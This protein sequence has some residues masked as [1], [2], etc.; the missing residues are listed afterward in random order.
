VDTIHCLE[1]VFRN[2]HPSY[3]VVVC[4]NGSD[5]GSLEYI[6]EWAEG[7]RNAVTAVH[8]FLASL[9]TPPVAKPIQYVMYSRRSAEQGGDQHA[10]TAR[11]I[12]IRNEQNEGFAAGNNVA[13]RF[14]LARQDLAYAWI[15][16]N[17]TLVAPAALRALVRCVRRR[18]RVGICGSTLVYYDSP[19]VVQTRGGITYNRWFATIRAI[20]Q[21]TLIHEPCDVRR[22]ERMMSYPAG[23]S[24]LVSRDFLQ[25]VGL[26]SE[27]Y[28]LYCE[29]L[30]WATRARGRF[31]IAYSP[32]S[33]VYH[34]EGSTIRAADANA[35]V[36]R[37]D[38]YAHRNRLRYTKQFFPM[39]LPTALIRTLFAALARLWRGQPKRAWIILRLMFAKDTYAF[40]RT[41]GGP[42][43]VRGTSAR[44]AHVQNRRNSLEE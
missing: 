41:D 10:A 9:T 17:D 33:I 42:T 14:A 3:Q 35:E 26:L 21:G 7:K 18:P 39:G 2:S 29:E 44:T 25:A 1:S 27:D 30:D 38:Y 37:A 13:L 36:P 40:P 6:R 15:L 20:G 4:D 8:P 16:N 34:K 31:E 24:M 28:F 12:L 22:V 43:R 19:D 11:L 5:D 32:E 23:A